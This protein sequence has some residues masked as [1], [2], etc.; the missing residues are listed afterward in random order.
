M[1][2]RRLDSV[3][4]P[5]ERQAMIHYT[6]MCYRQLPA[7]QQKAIEGRIRRAC[8]KMQD[9]YSRPVLLWLTGQKSM[10]MVVQEF[11]V[12]DKRMLAIRRKVF[13]NW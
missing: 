12:S 6:L 9:E 7:G 5:Y 4:L 1:R 2:F 8:G 11:G 13:E 3:R 10:H